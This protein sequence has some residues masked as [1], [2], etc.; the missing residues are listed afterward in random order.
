MSGGRLL[1]REVESHHS[2]PFLLDVCPVESFSDFFCNFLHLLCWYVF[3]VLRVHE[4]SMTI[5]CKPRAY[6]DVLVLHA[7]SFNI[8]DHTIYLEGLLPSLRDYPYSLVVFSSFAVV[9]Y[10]TSMLH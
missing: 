5:S 10:P 3:D 1:S 7:H 4:F 9:Q 6:I 8:S 2:I